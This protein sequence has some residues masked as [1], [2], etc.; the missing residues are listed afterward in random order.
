MEPLI[1]S[2]RHFLRL[3][4]LSA[5]GWCSANALALADLVQPKNGREKPKSLIMLWMNG[6]ASQ[7]ETFDPHPGTKI[8]GPTTAIDTTAKGVRIASGL[9]QIA[10]QMHS[11]A[12]VRSLVTKEG[13]HD[14]GQYLMKT[15]FR[16]NPSVVHPSLGAICSAELPDLG[17]E[18]PRYVAIMADKRFSRGGYLGETYDPFLTHDPQGGLPDVKARVSNER[19]DRRISGLSVVESAMMKRNPSVEAISLHREQTDRAVAMMRSSQLEAFRIEGESESTRLA[20]GDSGFGRG[21]LAARRLVEAGVRCVEVQLGGWDTH[22]E[23]FE[24]HAPLNAQLDPAMSALIRDLRDR[25]MLEST[26][27]LWVSEFGRT[28]VI[29]PLEGRDHWINGFSVALAGGGIKGG[30]VVG[31]T[32]PA[33]GKEV[34]ES[35]SVDDVYATVLK[36]LGIAGGKDHTTAEGRPIKLSDGKPMTK[37]LST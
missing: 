24:H 6:G 20:Y 4:S 17:V 31:E 25:E 16:P 33:G 7:L 13:D 9:P 1:L 35:C 12:L 11:I 2:R 21:C 23:N 19:M 37:L 5:L 14:R 27:V 18:I 26:V 34:K 8:G 30:V 10:E 36:A 22:R 32:D 3:S 15:G 29:N 28:P